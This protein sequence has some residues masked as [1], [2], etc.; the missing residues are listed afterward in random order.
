MI[1]QD[2]RPTALSVKENFDSI[3]INNFSRLFLFAKE[4]VLFDEEAE[5]IVQDIFLMLWEK[6]EA[7]RVDVS[8]TAYLFTLVKNKCIDF[9]RHQMVEQMYSENVKHEYNEELNVKLFALES[10]DHNFSSEEDIET[11]LRNAIDKLPERCRL[12]FIKSRIEG[13]KY[14]EIAEE[15][16]LS[17]NTVE[18]Q[19][20]IALKKLREE[21][22]DYLPL[23]LFL[24]I[25]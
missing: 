24:F 18:G 5:N 25:C 12:I 11:L 16:N 3:Y 14:K 4:Y 10:F 17:V 22:K 13:K 8:L 23:L 1:Y 15:L 7:L 19:I 6:R 2:D 20:S 21:L 9:L